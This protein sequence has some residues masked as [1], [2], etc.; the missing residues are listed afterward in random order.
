MNDTLPTDPL[1][2]DPI[3][4]EEF[5]QEDLVIE[6]IAPEFLAHKKSS[7]WYLKLGCI[8]VTIA[9]VIFLVTHDKIASA[10]VLFCAVLLGVF[11]SRQ[12]RQI[13]YTLG[14]TGF[15]IANKFHSYDDFRSFGIVPEVGI[16]SIV[17]MPLKRL[18]QTIT[19]YYD[20]VN[21]DEITEILVARLPYEDHKHDPF[22]KLLRKIKF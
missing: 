1:Q 12:P 4:T 22:E 11:A 16:S 19:I 6:W 10:F 14:S 5:M 13:T 7:D 8:A 21:E 20:Q 9:L 15:E 2:T 3:L 17:L 18:S